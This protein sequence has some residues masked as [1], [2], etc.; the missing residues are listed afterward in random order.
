MQRSRLTSIKEGVSVH[1]AFENVPSLVQTTF[2]LFTPD[3]EN[4]ISVAVTLQNKPPDYFLNTYNIA[5]G[6]LKDVFSN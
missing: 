3:K 5:T 2:F 4:L 6:T 1:G